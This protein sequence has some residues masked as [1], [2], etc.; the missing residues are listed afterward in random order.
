LE[1]G[2]GGRQASSVVAYAEQPPAVLHAVQSLLDATYRKVYTRDRRGAPIP[3]RF[4]VK[5]VHRVMNDQVWREYAGTREE[6]RSRCAAQR[7]S[8]PDGAQTM[9]HL[10]ANRLTALPALDSEVNETWLFHGTTGEAARGIAENDFRLDL[11]GSNAGTLYGKGIYLAEN[12]SKSDEYG[13]GPRG[14]AGEEAERGFEAPRPPPGPPPPLVHESYILLCRSVLGRVLYTDDL[15]PDPDRLQ[16]SC[17]S[18]EFES[19]LGDRLKT[20]GTFREVIV[21]SDDHV[22]PEFIV[23]Y[24]RIFFHERFAQVYEAMLRRRMAGQFQGPTND[25]LSVLQSLWNVYGMPNHGKI[26]KWQLLDLL[27]AVYQPPQNE[28][29]DLDQTFQEWDTKG[30]SFI[31]WDE[32][33]QEVVQR[34]KDGI[35]CSGPERFA[36]VYSGMLQRQRQGSFEGPDAGES[37]VLRMVWYRYASNAESIDKWQLL[38][39]LK[40][41][42]QPPAD[43]AGDLD[44]T[45]AEIDTKKDGVIDYQEFIQEIVQR[46]KDGMGG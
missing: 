30:D 44:A 17:L 35:T 34:V 27:M 25:E 24:D 29:E 8:V 18:G 1:G 26:N 14:P 13:E 33:L 36:E 5:Q 45:F 10:S 38:A 9:N 2:A 39:L 4:V 19:V 31:D 6:I 43:E 20:R 15:K 16:R 21:Y 37:N 23:K 41:I 11:T 40:A 22:Y 46:V 28:E 3:D 42:N 7:P 12:S 32:F